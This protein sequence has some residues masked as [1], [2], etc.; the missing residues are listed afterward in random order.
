MKRKKEKEKRGKKYSTAKID[1][2]RERD[3]RAG[4]GRWGP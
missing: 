4:M 3:Y 2:G 1:G